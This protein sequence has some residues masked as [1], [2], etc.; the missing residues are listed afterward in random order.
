MVVRPIEMLLLVAEGAFLQF[1]WFVLVLLKDDWG[2]GVF[3]AV[4]KH[5]HTQIS[6]QGW[7]LWV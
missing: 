2:R 3:L 6:T 1:N 7:T 4:N 5:T